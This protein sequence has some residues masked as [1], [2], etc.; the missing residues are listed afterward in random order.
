MHNTSQCEFGRRAMSE[1]LNHRVLLGARSLV[2]LRSTWTRSYL[3]LTRNNRE[4]D[5]TDPRA[6]RFCAYGALVRSAYDLTGDAGRASL[7]AGGVAM[8][9]TGRDSP[10]K[11]F[12][13]IYAMNDGPA[14]SSRRAILSL[15]D[16]ALGRA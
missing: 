1:S 10:Q 7:L 6:M 13:E 14:V 2:E 4:C 5:P 11:A 3:A 8:S 9:L 12:E 16:K 15:F